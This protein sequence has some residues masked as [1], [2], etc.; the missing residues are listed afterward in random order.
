MLG[1]VEFQQIVQQV[2]NLVGCDSAQL[3]LGCPEPTLRHPLLMA[4]SISGTSYRAVGRTGQRQTQE[5][6][7][8]TDLLHNE[9]IL[10]LCD[11]AIQSGRVQ[12]FDNWQSQTERT[13][14]RS[15][16][17]VP[18]ERPAGVLGFLLL[19]DSRVGA[20]YAGEHLLLS[21]YM[22]RV[23]QQLETLLSRRPSALPASNV[24]GNKLQDIALQENA[25][26]SQEQEQEQ[27]KDLDR[28]KNEFISMM[29]HEIRNP[30]TAIKGYAVLLQAY[31]IPEQTNERDVAVMSPQ[32]Q[33]EYLNNI[34]EQTRHL[35]V[36]INDLLDISRLHAR[37]LQLRY[38]QVDVVEVCRRVVGLMQ[39]KYASSSAPVAEIACTFEPNLPRLWTD[40]DRL[41]QV[42]TNLLDNAMKYSPNGGRIHVEVST[43]PY[44]GRVAIA[45]SD[46][47]IGIAQEQQHYL[48][49]PFKRLEHALTHDIPGAGLGL[50]I[51]RKLVEAMQ[52]EIILA[53]REGEGTTVTCSL[54]YEEHEEH[55]EHEMHNLGDSLSFQSDREE[56]PLHVG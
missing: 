3:F 40:P 8:N 18:L 42:L 44:A 23:A 41:Q 15:V 5:Q 9:R 47:G 29:S 28:L 21:R 10:A 19:L 13:P 2:R 1:D 11:V 36:L 34:M 7:R 39:Q 55:S 27:R 32:R 51:T 43:V 14:L 38:Q 56:S 49:Q 22:P 25:H 45:V 17:I 48:F 20:F 50:Y 12:S 53:S 26:N 54:P 46:T 30:L 37:R 35:E 16:A 6:V 24:T 4:W 33:R 31:G 52:G